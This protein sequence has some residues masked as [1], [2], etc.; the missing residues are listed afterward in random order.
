MFATS[1][2]VY[3][4]SIFLKSCRG[5]FIN[6]ITN[7][8]RFMT[9]PSPFHP[10]YYIGLWSNVNFWQIPLPPKWMTSLMVGSIGYATLCTTTYLKILPPFLHDLVSD[11]KATVAAHLSLVHFLHCISSA[12]YWVTDIDKTYRI[13]INA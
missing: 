2:W 13:Y 10:F 9:P 3:I 5:P 1:E 12:N 7:F 6:D 8:L 4:C 11:T